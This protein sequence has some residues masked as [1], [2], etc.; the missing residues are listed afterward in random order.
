MKS[1]QVFHDYC[2]GCGLCKVALGLSF[3]EDEKGFLYPLLNQESEV[4]CSKVCPAGGNALA[5]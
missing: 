4:F 1:K 3:E 2:T 5:N